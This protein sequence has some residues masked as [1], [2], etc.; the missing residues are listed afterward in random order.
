MSACAWGAGSA[1][2]LLRW[3]VVGAGLLVTQAQALSES[4]S[5]AGDEL[6]MILNNTFT[7]G[8]GIRMQSPNV[9]LIGKSNLDRNVCGVPFQ[10]CQGV[11]KDQIF[12]AQKLVRAPGAASVNGD[13]G[14]LNYRKYQ[15]FQAPAKLTSDLTLSYE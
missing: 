10:S 6:K 15:F 14:D 4:F 12:P 13:D 11:F 5:I 7:A 2:A 9:D 8:G 1:R 3:C